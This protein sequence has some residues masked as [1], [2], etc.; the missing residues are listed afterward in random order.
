LPSY[1]DDVID[2]WAEYTVLGN[3]DL[4]DIHLYEIVNSKDETGRD[5]MSKGEPIL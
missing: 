1:V 4:G 3:Q 2:V 5:V